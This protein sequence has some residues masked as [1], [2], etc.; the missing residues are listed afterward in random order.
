[1]TE[2]GS[3]T[4]FYNVLVEGDDMD[5]PIADAARAILDGHL[6]L[7]RRLASRGH[8]PPIDVTDSISRVMPKVANPDHLEAAA[9]IKTM[10]SAYAEA[11]DLI[12]IGAY[13]R[14]SNPQIDRALQYIDPINSFLKQSMDE[15]S[16]YEDHVGQMLD[17]LR[18]AE[19]ETEDAE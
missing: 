15:G 14:G 8:Y 19:V 18:P 4:G 5:E 2:R 7:S 1:M 11:E 10:M 13:A 12:N 6:V 16:D 3:I 17:T 9:E